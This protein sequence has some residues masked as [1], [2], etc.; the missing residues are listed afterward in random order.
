M[1]RIK[2]FVALTLAFIFSLVS[3]AHAQISIQSSTMSLG[4]KPAFVM[5]FENADKKLTEK[6]WKEHVKDYGKVEKNK[7]AKELYMTQTTIPN[8]GGTTPINI[9]FKV[10]EGKNMTRALVFIDDG[11]KFIG[12]GDDEEDG[13]RNFLTDY[14][15]LVNK[16]VAKKFM[17]DGEDD[18]K[19][20]NKKLSKL[21][22]KNKD[23]HKDIDKYQKK[24]IEA[25][26]DIENNL[27]EQD[28]ANQ[29]IEM[30]KEKVEAL[31]EAYNNVG[32]G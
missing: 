7:K 20:L 9:Y 3:G 11:A 24:I 17:E 27:K 4:N 2:L 18:L 31:I 19:D 28:D 6:K 15:N 8:L 5:E 26:E 32:K 21:E 16:E 14:A 29:N 25:E 23:Y 30:Q 10:E 22:D 1:K 12:N 13:V